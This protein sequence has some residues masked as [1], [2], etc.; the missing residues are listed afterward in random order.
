MPWSSSSPWRRIQATAQQRKQRNNV[1]R[2]MASGDCLDLEQVGGLVRVS[3]LSVR[4][5]PPRLGS[6]KVGGIGEGIVRRSVGLCNNLALEIRT[7]CELQGLIFHFISALIRERKLVNYLV[8]VE[9]KQWR[10]EFSGERRMWR[11]K[12]WRPNTKSTVKPQGMQM[13][14]AIHWFEESYVKLRFCV[15]AYIARFIQTT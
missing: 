2:H 15:Y 3:G 6:D 12:W 11:R 5:L 1:Q 9:A 4:S 14:V 10:R 7:N 8:R 13:L